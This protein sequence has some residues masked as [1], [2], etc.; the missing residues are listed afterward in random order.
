M[1]VIYGS[2]ELS[3]T[4]LFTKI[5]HIYCNYTNTSEINAILKICS[6]L[7]FDDFT[8]ISG[9]V[10][11]KYEYFQYDIGILF[12][13]LDCDMLMTVTRCICRFFYWTI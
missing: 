5:E 11:I 8:L 2:G 9:I 4:F 1:Q 10:V 3:R 13:P 12:L 7:V 6:S